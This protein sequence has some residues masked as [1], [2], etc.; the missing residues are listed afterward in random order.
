VLG[1]INSGRRLLAAVLGVFAISLLLGILL[2]LLLPDLTWVSSAVQSLGN[3]V[4]VVLVA[5]YFALRN[6]WNP[7]GKSTEEN[8]RFVR[9]ESWTWDTGPAQ[10]LKAIE[11]ALVYA[12][13]RVTRDDSSVVAI[14]GSD[15]HLKLF[16]MLSPWKFPVRALYQV[17]PHGTDG[18]Q[19]T[20]RI[21]DRL[22]W[23]A[24]QSMNDWQDAFDKQVQTLN[25]AAR[26]ATQ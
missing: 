19:V 8:P 3:A 4:I 15:M 21:H 13:A 7:R 5:W 23:Y 6:N 11:Q 10:S 1:R 12:G 14:V 24:V 20:A 18:T 2:H 22:G 25:S 17:L 9:E 16:G 26:K